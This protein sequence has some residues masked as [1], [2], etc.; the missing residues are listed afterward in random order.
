M[1]LC[2]SMPFRFFSFWANFGGWRLNFF[3]GRAATWM[4][5]KYSGGGGAL[6]LSDRGGGGTHWTTPK[7]AVFHPI[8]A[9][10]YTP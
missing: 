4:F 10:R 3:R 6:G 1:Y 7:P 5:L 8:Q 2:V 9:L